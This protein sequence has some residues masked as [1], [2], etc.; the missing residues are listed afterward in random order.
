[1]PPQTTEGRRLKFIERMLGSVFRPDLGK[2]PPP[3]HEADPVSIHFLKTPTAEAD[4]VSLVTKASFHV[5]LKDDFEADKANVKV[6]IKVPILEDDNEGEGDPILITV[7]SLENKIEHVLQADVPVE[8]SK[9]SPI[10]FDLK[11]EPYSPLW[12]TRVV[13]TVSRE[14]E[15]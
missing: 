7:E 11:T 2:V 13:V 3:P 15:D 1:L 4:G 8:L 12:S 5:S 14:M 10:R 9:G 6:Q